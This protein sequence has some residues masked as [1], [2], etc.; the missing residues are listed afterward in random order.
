[1]FSSWYALRFFPFH[2]PF[3]SLLQKPCQIYKTLGWITIPSTAIVS[4]MFFGFLVA[5]EEI[6]SE[7]VVLLGALFPQR[8]T[9]NHRRLS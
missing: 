5:G 1:M 3:E 2:S 6:E 8:L 9:M 7:F 4:F